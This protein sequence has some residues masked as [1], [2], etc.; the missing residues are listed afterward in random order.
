ME[1]HVNAGERDGGKAALKFDVAFGLLL[2][3]S[4]GMAFL[5]DLAEHLLD[6]FFSHLCD[7]LVK[8]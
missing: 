3:L 6:F 2:R 5:E 8:K 7:E 1:W 4:L